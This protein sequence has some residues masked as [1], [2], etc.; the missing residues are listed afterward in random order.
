MYGVAQWQR[1]IQ[2]VRG[3]FDSNG[4]GNVLLFGPETGQYTPAIY[5]NYITNTPGY[6]GGPGYPQLTG[7]LD[8]AVGA[9]AF[10][11]YA[12]CSLG[13]TQQAVAAHPKDMWMTEYGNPV[14][15]N[16]LQWTLDMMSAMAAHL[17][18]VPHN[19]WFWW[20][21]WT[22][23][24]GAPPF[25]QLLGG[26]T[27]PIYSRR[28]YTLQKLFWTVRP[29]WHV[30][31]MWTSDPDLQTGWGSQ[32]QCTARVNMIGFASPDGRTAVVEITN[33]T[34]RN[35]QI[36]VGGLPGGTQRSWR[37][38]WWNNM[39]QQQTTN[40]YRGYSTISVPANSVVIAVTQ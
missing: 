12:E 11:T 15:T 2:A 8:H 5:S 32:N 4:L 18:I 26:T 24:S 39:A 25:G 28:F 20:M 34:N 36:Q 3:S 40:V 35:K 33:T 30:H 38:D 7:Y 22:Q 19:Y 1:V 27:T 9:Y 23:T 14:G 13:Q 29:G 17:V 37:T 6:F 21:G 10:H 16:D 31:S